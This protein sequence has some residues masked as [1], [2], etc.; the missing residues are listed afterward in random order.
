MWNIPNLLTMARTIAAVPI[1]A[2][3]LWSRWDAAFAL[4]IVAALTD[5]LDGWLARRWNQTSD[6]GRF[7]DPIADK[8]IVAAVLIAMLGARAV[9]A[10]HGDG[11]AALPAPGTW[12]VIL[13]LTREI[14]VAGLREYLGPRNVVLHVSP[15][16]K[17]KTALQLIAIGLLLAAPV[18]APSL[19]RTAIFY[20]AQ[21]GGAILAFSALLAWITAWSYLRAG[22]RHMEPPR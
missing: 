7:L 15:L 11:G 18:L 16:A 6:F 12:P 5:W 19:D 10:E 14:L 3:I 20:V 8:L 1:A 13:I 4:F 17:W 22:L 21:A 9:R 2:L